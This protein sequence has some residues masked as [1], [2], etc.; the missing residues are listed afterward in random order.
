MRRPP[1]TAWTALAALLASCTVAL[2][3]SAPAASAAEEVVERPAD[4][5]FAVEG[6]GWG[7]GRGMS[8]WGAQGAAS[9]G[10]DAETI[11]S[12]YYPG[13]ARAVLA[14]AP[15]RVL[16]SGDDGKD[17]VV[18]AAPGLAVTDAATGASS[19]LPAGPSRWRVTV[20]AACLHVQSLTG[21]TWT[22]YALGGAT[23]HAGPVRFGGPALV[24]LA[25]ASGVSRDYRGTVQ[26]V[27]VSATALQ[28]VVVLPLEDYLLG[29]V[30]RE[31][32]ASWRPAA[33]EAQA[34]AARSYSAHKRHRVAG[35]GN[36]D[37][38]DSTSCQVFGGSAV[39]STSGTRTELEPASTTAAV[40][41]T[42]GV[43]R[44]YG[45]TPVHAEFSSS[46]GGWSTT[47]DFP[48]LRAARDDWDGALPSSVHAWRATLRATDLERRFPAVGTLRRLR[49]TARDGNGAWGGRVTAVVL[50]GVSATGAA[51]RVSTTGA[52]VYAARS[53]PGTSD[54]LRSSWWRIVGAAAP[55]PATVT[56]AS[57]VVAQSAA[58]TLVR[59]PGTSTATL[60]AT[61]R[62]SGSSAWP[63]AA[64]GLAPTSPVPTPDPL[65]PR[66]VVVRHG[67]RSGAVTV[68]PGEAAT[69]S[70]A[71]DAAAVPAGTH[72]RSYQLRAGT[73]A[74]FGAVL[75][76]R[77][78]VADARLTAAAAGPVVG[79]SPGGVLADG[80]TVVVPRRGSTEVRLSYRATGNLA[81]PAT[82]GS[83]VQLG[84]SVARNRGSASAGAGW[85]SWV[86]PGLQLE[87]PAGAGA[88][89]PGGTG[90]FRL[91][92]HGNGLAAGA[93]VEH[94]EP[95][96][97]GRGWL[98][99]AARSLVVVRVDPAVSRAAM[100]HSR[101]PA[102]VT[103]TSDATGRGTLVVRLRNL[104]ASAWAVGGE[105]LGTLAGVPFPL[106]TGWT[107]PSRP[108]AL[109]ANSI[110]PGAGTVAPGE[111]GEW[112]IPIS[113]VGKRPG[114]YVLDVAAVASTGRY[115]PTV[116]TTVT[117]V[118]PR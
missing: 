55:A 99:G 38:C 49:V 47:G 118:A 113:A 104:G 20:D 36:F 62:N 95:L 48:Y 115:G 100:L 24:R 64:L 40:R 74:P 106:A 57:Q 13:T 60:T 108:P 88:V 58:P 32:S 69:L 105:R 29:V 63:T 42:A 17:T 114:S 10:V 77:I 39:Y 25:Y 45:G 53:W 66:A 102:A 3:T 59:P 46:N 96:W 80:R 14:P 107:S 11:V 91:R 15:I 19:V 116:R 93:T 43:V 31:S 75:T 35:G 82:A 85:S 28:S 87:A 5:V 41:A 27:R 84:T 22:P 65:V 98:E 110:R 109:A 81:W 8:Q 111:V 94:F 54:G 79:T 97:A 90:T 86:R 76:W 78:A 71:V 16:L 9:Q 56:A 18:H 52:G 72:T 103:L 67:S 7:H 6:H 50:E 23:A 26:A 30:P 1:R 51:T 4:G 12:T 68:E 89:A 92:L 83:P 101:S 70:L 73:G 21:T 37:I 61:V 33:L 112:R 44:T 117:V 2:V 34:I